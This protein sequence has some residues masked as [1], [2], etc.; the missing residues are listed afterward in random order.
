M[1]KFSF[2]HKKAFATFCVQVLTEA[3]DANGESEI[4]PGLSVN[5]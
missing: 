4:I 1:I 2:H 5:G 3:K